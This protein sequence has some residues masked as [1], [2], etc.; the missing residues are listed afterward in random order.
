MLGLRPTKS[1]SESQ[2]YTHI[3][4]CDI[5]DHIE[6]TL[7]V[8]RPSRTSAICNPVEE[9]VDI[10]DA[11]VIGEI[12]ND[13]E[14][15]DYSNTKVKGCKFCINTDGFINEDLIANATHETVYQKI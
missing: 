4:S 15:I 3:A 2:S 10:R 9:K 7:F 8:F 13:C 12:S 5:N 1:I 6:D 14:D 11:Y